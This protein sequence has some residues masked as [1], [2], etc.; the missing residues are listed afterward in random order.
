[1]NGQH[2]SLAQRRERLVA[3]SAAQR[4]ALVANFEPLGRAAAT[5]DRIVAP[6]RR[7]PI[8]SAVLVT[9]V[10]LAGSRRIFDVATRAATIYML[11]RRRL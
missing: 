7:H 10:A 9:L 11:L 3:S 5:L 8:M 4:A 1:M 6:V 2:L